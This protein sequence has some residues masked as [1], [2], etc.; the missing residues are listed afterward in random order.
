MALE[1]LEDTS[2]IVRIAG[3]FDT[4]TTNAV[5]PEGKPIAW[6]IL[7]TVNDLRGVSLQEYLPG[8]SDH[9]A[10]YRT[11]GEFLQWVQELIDWGDRNGIIPIIC[12]YNLLFDLQTV[13][14]SLARMYPHM[15]TT[16]QTGKTVYTIDVKRDK[17]TILRFWDAFHLNK[18]GLAAMGALAGLPKLK[19]DWDYSLIRTPETPLTA[20]EKAY[21]RR[22]VQVIPAYLHAILVNNPWIGENELGWNVITSTSLVRRFANANVGNLYARGGKALNECYRIRCQTELPKTFEQYA[23][24]RACFRG[25]LCFTGAKLASVPV[26]NVASLDVT[27]MHHTFMAR[28][29]PVEFKPDYTVK[30]VYLTR[31]AEQVLATPLT[32]VLRNYE[33]PF[34]KAFHGLF[35]FHNLR[36]REGSGF[37]EWDIAT[38]AHSKFRETA[39]RYAEHMG[40]DLSEETQGDY[41][42]GKG[43]RD[44]AINAIYA[45]G[46]LCSADYAEV[47][48]NEIELYIMSLVYQWDEMDVMEGEVSG[49]W[50]KCPDYIG[51]QSRLL[52]AQKADVK[53]LLKHY[54]PGKKFR[55]EIGAHVAA[56]IAAAARRGTLTSE[57]LESYYYH[58]KGMF[59]AI[60]GTQAE[61]E[62]KPRFK[63][64]DGVPTIDAETVTTPENFTQRRKFHS[65]VLYTFGERIVAGSRLHL[66]IAMK[67]L[68][69]H[70]GERIDVLGGDTDSLKIRCDA[71][72]TD[73]ELMNALKPLHD[74][75]DTCI[76]LGYMRSREQFRGAYEL[77]M[78]DVGHFDIDTVGAPIDGKRC[79]RYPWHVE[80]WN[81]CRVS[82]RND[83]ETDI[84][85]AGLSRPENAY[86][87]RD[88]YREAI[89]AHGA[90][91]ALRNGIGYRLYLDFGVC[92]RLG[93]TSPLPTDRV[94]MTVTDYKGHECRVQTHEAIALYNEG[95]EIGSTLNPD[96]LETLTYLE[97]YYARVVDMGAR[98][99]HAPEGKEEQ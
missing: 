13:I 19:G 44:Q 51:L 38:L 29:I 63:M 68:W 5:T 2:R 64:I 93:R 35:G 76:N 34:L 40:A 71:D 84:T 94:D 8:E 60:Y 67:L 22:D 21:A 10:F 65:R 91:W 72:V 89:A 47:W 81:K 28:A 97:R 70:F 66:V 96:T 11:E 46:K 69:E 1:E 30:H 37:E 49:N 25:G 20:R 95:K 99:I 86:S 15:E 6:P 9:I 80:L 41:E 27:S 62:F 4:E 78:P 87:M 52:Y 98:F 90:R 43:Y 32:E 74:A 61:N 14:E 39:V 55:G 54:T 57:D 31:A 42:R 36:R 73:A 85:C 53:T 83:G 58:V 75:A 45:F 17:Q 16:A 3:V 33:M 7:Y 92:H 88:W 18:M 23:W 48:L 82:V 79:T 24:R 50:R 12:A 77:D 56:P 59:N 26:Q